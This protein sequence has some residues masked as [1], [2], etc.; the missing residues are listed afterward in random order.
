[1][2]GALVAMVSNFTY[3]WLMLS[4]SDYDDETAIQTLTSLYVSALE[5][6]STT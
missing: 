6:P 2:A 3:F 4:E 1:M 5:L